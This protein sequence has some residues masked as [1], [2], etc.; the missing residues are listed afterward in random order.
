LNWRRTSSTIA[1][2]ALPTLF[3]VIALNQYGSM[4]PTSRP[5]NTCARV[6]GRAYQR[7]VAM[8]PTSKPATAWPATSTVRPHPTPDTLG[9][10]SPRVDK[11]RTRTPAH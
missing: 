3:M 1:S 8:A 7:F 5:A 10:P 9:F 2:A 11:Q 4:A 6:G